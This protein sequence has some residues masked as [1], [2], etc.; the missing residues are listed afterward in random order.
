LKNIIIAIDGYSSCG[1]STLAR[2]LAKELNYHYIDTGAMYRAVTL[3]LIQNQIDIH[4]PEMVANVLN[5]ISIAFDFDEAIQTQ[6]TLLNGENIENEIRINPRVASAVSDVSALSEVRRFLVKQQQELGKN[7]GIVMDGR[8]IGTVV[9]PGA[10]IKLFITAEPSIRANR[11]L[12]ELKEK[13][14]NTTY[15]EV[16]ANLAKRDRNDTTRADSPLVKASDAIEIDNS[17]LSKDEQ[18]N[19]V[20]K[21]V[22]GLQGSEAS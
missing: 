20:L 10:E 8:D 12:D 4:H 6:I 18:L 3:Y 16:L 17:N 2:Q 14:Q 11:R 5:Q 7:K 21:L 22:Y 13:G 1:K 19:Q 9:F 15:E